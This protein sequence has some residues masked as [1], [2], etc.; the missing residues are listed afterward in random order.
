MDKKGFTIVELIMSFTLATVVIFFLFNIVFMLKDM[1]VE[2]D[3]Q[4]T[5]LV[6]QSIFSQTVNHD[7]FS[8]KVNEIKKCN[9][10]DSLICVEI[11]YDGD[12]GTKKLVVTQTSVARSVQ[13]GDYIY[14]LED[15]EDFNFSNITAFDVNVKACQINTGTKKT[16]YINVPIHSKKKNT[17]NFGLRL[18]YPIGTSTT[19]KDIPNC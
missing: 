18:I 10:T 12:L 8:N 2:N 13:Y 17:K 16:L 15:T 1:Y 9:D 11:V 3:A 14:P 7:L 6:E 4:S 5:L 19:V